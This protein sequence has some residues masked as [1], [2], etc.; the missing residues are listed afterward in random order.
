MIPM[1]MQEKPRGSL[2]GRRY[3][4][5]DSNG[6]SLSSSI[7]VKSIDDLMYK[8]TPPPR[9]SALRSFRTNEY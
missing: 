2:F 3:T 1:I 5:R 9:L 7:V 6:E 8:Q 4:L